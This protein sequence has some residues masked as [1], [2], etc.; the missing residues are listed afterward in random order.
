[1]P[2]KTMT[3]APNLRRAA[4]RK[5]SRTRGDDRAELGE[6]TIYFCSIQSDRSRFPNMQIPR[7]SDGTV[8]KPAVRTP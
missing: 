2:G 6:C 8:A 3:S 7:T 5:T 4:F 1:M